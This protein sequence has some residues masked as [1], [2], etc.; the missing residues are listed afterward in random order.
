MWVWGAVSAVLCDDWVG[1]VRAVGNGVPSLL[2]KWEG[3]Q[4]Q[5]AEADAWQILSFTLTRELGKQ[6]VWSLHSSKKFCPKEVMRD[7]T[8]NNLVLCNLRKFNKRRLMTDVHQLWGFVCLFTHRH[9]RGALSH[10]SSWLRARARWLAK[11]EDH[12]SPAGSG[13]AWSRAFSAG[14][15][16]GRRTAPSLELNTQNCLA[17]RSPIPEWV[18]TGPSPLVEPPR[19]GTDSP[20]PTLPE[21]SSSGMLTPPLGFPIIMTS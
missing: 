16:A 20:H 3:W 6:L 17:C 5:C 11:R 2:G 14:A 8:Q 1:T 9:S 15:R 19:R 21:K 10:A 12:G 13:S 7:K 18:G 4:R